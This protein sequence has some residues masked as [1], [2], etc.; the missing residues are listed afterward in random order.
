MFKKQKTLSGLQ[1]LTNNFDKGKEM[2]L[3]MMNLVTKQEGNASF[4]NQ[5]L[6]ELMDMEN[7]ISSEM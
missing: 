7:T 3:S 4:N 6:V 5:S 1:N 2:K